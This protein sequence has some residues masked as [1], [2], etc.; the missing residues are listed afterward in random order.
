MQ[1]SFT[2]PCFGRS[3]T[4]ARELQHTWNAHVTR[5]EFRF[6]TLGRAPCVS[7]DVPT[8]NWST[9]SSSIVV[10]REGPDLGLSLG[11]DIIRSTI[12][13]TGHDLDRTGGPSRQKGE[14]AP[15]P[16]IAR[17]K[18][19]PFCTREES[20]GR[21]ESGAGSIGSFASFQKRS[22]WFREW[23][24]RACVHRTWLLLVS[25]TSAPARTVVA[26][27][28]PLPLPPTVVIAL[29]DR[30]ASRHGRLLLRLID[31]H[32]SAHRLGSR[33]RVLPRILRA[34]Q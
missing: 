28:V 2:G 23:V 17:G 7:V 14:G 29:Q 6:E 11:I 32:R 18:R 8:A 33:T 5:T 19:P 22:F 13:I 4:P 16:D 9:L 1:R 27:T 10:V 31:F 3:A 25:D 15:I 34:T 26:R 21:K 30:P 20:W 12:E 24:P